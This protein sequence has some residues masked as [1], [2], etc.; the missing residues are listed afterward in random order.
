MKRVDLTYDEALKAFVI[1]NKEIEKLVKQNIIPELTLPDSAY[2]LL[3][4]TPPAEDAPIVG[5]LLGCDG[6]SY[7]ADWNY[8]RAI[9]KSGAKIR[10]IDHVHPNTEL[11]ECSGLILPGGAF[12]S[13]ERYY[14]DPGPEPK[15][16]PRAFAYIVLIRQAGKQGIPILGICAGAQMVAGEF[17]LK[18][19]RNTEHLGGNLAH[20]SKELNAH[21]VFITD[22][23]L[24]EM[25]GSW[26]WANTRHSECADSD[27]SLSE[28]KIFAHAED[29]CPEAWGN[30]EKHILCIQWHPEDGATW[31]NKKMQKI[32]DWLAS[33]AKIYQSQQQ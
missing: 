16:S 18:L 9:A 15:L 30:W 7:S 1:S 32:Y 17:G 20:K 24:K 10:F 5:F 12:V 29:G 27:D 23:S 19:H 33:E 4:V 11:S 25:L 26:L 14:T 3:H 13:P 31:G 6:D 21:K 2:D 8:V 22:Q 28:L